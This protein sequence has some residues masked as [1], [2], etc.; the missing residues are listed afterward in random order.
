MVSNP[1]FTTEGAADQSTGGMAD[2]PQ[3]DKLLQIVSM[4]AVLTAVLAQLRARRQTADLRLDA[5]AGG[6]P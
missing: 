2:L 6:Q 1:R 5:V 4:A 3:P